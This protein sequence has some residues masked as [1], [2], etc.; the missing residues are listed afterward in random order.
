M[1]ESAILPQEPA[2]VNGEL[3]DLKDARIEALDRGFIFGDGLYEVIPFFEG[4]FYLANEHLER[5]RQGAQEMLFENHPEPAELKEK[6]KQLLKKSGLK[7]GLAYLQ[8]TRGAAPRIHHFPDN[9]RPNVFMFVQEFEFPG[10]EK[11][12]HG[13]KTILV[14]DERWNRCNV[15]SVNLLPNCYYKEQARRQGAYEA[16]QVHPQVGVTEGTSSNVFGVKDGVIYTAPLGQRIL[17]GITRDT[18]VELAEEEGLKLKERFMT[19]HDLYQCDELF[20][21]SSACYALPINQVDQ[22]EYS[23]SRYNITFQLQEALKRHIAENLEE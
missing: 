6:A 19:T 14:P 2:Y 17:R 21:T 13:V 5:Y 9:P 23:V 20:L 11:M 12:L 18:V 7:E 1:K 15:K 4:K 16:V 8:V 3:V 10:P 22:V